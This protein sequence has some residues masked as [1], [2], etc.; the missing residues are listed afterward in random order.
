MAV[1]VSVAAADVAEPLAAAVVGEELLAEEPHAATP[2]PRPA[3]IAT[4]A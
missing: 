1:T 2:S 3:I 4:E